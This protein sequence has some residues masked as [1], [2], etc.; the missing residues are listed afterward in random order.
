MLWFSHKYEQVFPTRQAQIVLD[1]CNVS[2]VSCCAKYI[3]KLWQ[4]QKTVR[5]KTQPS[6]ETLIATPKIGVRLQSRTFA[7]A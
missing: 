2:G 3:L 7:A 1:L 6:Q 4:K 5:V